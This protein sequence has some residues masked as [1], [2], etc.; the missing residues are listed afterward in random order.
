MAQS[1]SLVPERSEN[2]IRTANWA[3]V[4]KM[5]FYQIRGKARK[6]SSAEKCDM[7][8]AVSTKGGLFSQSGKH[9]NIAVG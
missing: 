8:R 3:W 5:E 2:E 9:F 6:W 4:G 7:W 1:L